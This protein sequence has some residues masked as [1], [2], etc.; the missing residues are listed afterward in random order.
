MIKMVV[1]K[2]YGY[3]PN[4]CIV[5]RRT[6]G[7]GVQIAFP[8]HDFLPITLTQSEGYSLQKVLEEIVD[9]KFF[10]K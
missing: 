3:R 7:N 2:E 4:D 10:E 5:L 1:F 9:V 6:E 8:F